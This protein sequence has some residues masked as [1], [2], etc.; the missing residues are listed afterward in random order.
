MMPKIIFLNPNANNGR[1]L[2]KW[3]YLN[4]HTNYINKKDIVY[5]SLSTIHELEI[6]KIMRQHI[7]KG[8]R[9]FVA[10]GGDG[11]LNLLVNGYALLTSSEKEG[12]IIGAIGLGSSND[13]HKPTLE[14]INSSYGIIP[15]K[16]NF[17]KSTPRNLCLALFND[18][19]KYF[20][21]NASL[22]LTASGNDFFNKN[23]LIIRALK[24]IHIELAILFA[25]LISFIR[26]KN[27]LA[28]VTISN[29]ADIQFEKKIYL[30]N[31]AIIKTRFFAGSLHYPNAPKPNDGHFYVYGFFNLKPFNII[32]NF[33]RLYK[34]SIKSENKN[35]IHKISK[36]ITFKSINIFPFET[37]G[38]VYHTDQVTFKIEE[39][40]INICL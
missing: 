34:G 31:F 18:K 36:L 15:I 13:F 20:I 28:T 35:Y 9:Y 4:H 24:S 2:K 27:Y 19:K 14:S 10:A 1:A 37:D 17:N 40:G 23:G 25:S 26:Y 16:L 38:E 30:S 39:K 5:D 29:K 12:L 3:K 11:T 33:I 32:K 22:G 7:Q 8:H 21:I 6:S